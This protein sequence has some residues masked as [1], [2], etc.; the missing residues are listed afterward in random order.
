M[1]QRNLPA[2]LDKKTL[3]IVGSSE[4]IL[5]IL[6]LKGD[7]LCRPSFIA[8]SLSIQIMA[9]P[10]TNITSETL[11]FLL[12]D[13]MFFQSTK[14]TRWGKSVLKRNR[15]LP[16]LF[17]F[18]I[19]FL[20]GLCRKVIFL[21]DCHS[22]I[23]KY[24]WQHFVFSCSFLCQ[25]HSGRNYLNFLL[26]ASTDVFLYILSLYSSPNNKQANRQKPHILFISMC[27]CVYVSELVFSSPWFTC[28]SWFT[29]YIGILAHKDFSREYICM[30]LYI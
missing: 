4:Y 29:K 8:P 3:S 21:F 5:T 19:L 15:I 11:H 26:L 10:C 2:N 30:I 6:V 20:S 12:E 25:W 14:I 23:F 7:I 22:L 24:I 17:C 16:F 9:F 27:L 13:F 18:V 28:L 1:F